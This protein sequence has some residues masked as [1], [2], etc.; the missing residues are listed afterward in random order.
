[1]HE[2]PENSECPL[3]IWLFFAAWAGE[4]ELEEESLSWG[5][6]RVGLQMKNNLGYTCDTHFWSLG[7]SWT[8]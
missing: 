7:Y 8:Q 2:N 1:M 5:T 3:D 4:L 6:E